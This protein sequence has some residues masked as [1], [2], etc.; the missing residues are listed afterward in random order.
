MPSNRHLKKRRKCVYYCYKWPPRATSMVYPTWF[1]WHLDVSNTML[2]GFWCIR[3]FLTPL[4]ALRHFFHEIYRIVVHACNRKHNS[5]YSHEAFLIKSR[6]HIGRVSID[7]SVVVIFSTVKVLTKIW[8]P[9]RTYKT[10]WRVDF[11]WMLLSDKVRSYKTGGEHLII[12][13]T[14]EDDTYTF[15]VVVRQSSVVLL[16]YVGTSLCIHTNSSLRFLCLAISSVRV[17]NPSIRFV[18]DCFLI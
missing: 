8:I 18:L 3:H 9:L 1:W 4:F 6:T 13:W 2:V 15:D 12:F 11:I 7:R 14:Q 5:Q 17:G 16:I 10:K